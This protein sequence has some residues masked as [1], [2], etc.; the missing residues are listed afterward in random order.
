M[1]QEK[2]PESA[3]ES[4]EIKPANLKGNQPIILIGRTHAEAEASI[5][6]FGHLIRTVDSFEKYLMLGKTEC[7]R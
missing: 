2:I 4:N 1:V 5:F 6:Y 7:S 3:L